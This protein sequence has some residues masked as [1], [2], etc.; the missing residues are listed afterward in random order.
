MLKTF[1][2]VS[3]LLFF[4]LPTIA[5]K[6][7]NNYF[8]VQT[9][10]D[11]GT[12][13]GNFDTKTGIQLYLGIPFAKPPVGPLRWKAP[14]PLDNWKG[15]KKTKKFGPRPIQAIVYGI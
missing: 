13:E 2:S 8:A 1:L 10:I 11:N 14:Q 7:N 15:V 5:Q 9:K 3:F 4:T 12:I 6:N